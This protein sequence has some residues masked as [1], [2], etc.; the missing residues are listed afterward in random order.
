[1]KYCLHMATFFLSLLCLYKYKLRCLNHSFAFEPSTR[2]VWT[3]NKGRF[4]PYEVIECF[5]L[6]EIILAVR[7]NIGSLNHYW[8]FKILLVVLPTLGIWSII[9][10][11]TQIRYYNVLGGLK[12]YL[13]L[14]QFYNVWR[15]NVCVI[16]MICVW[17]IIS[18]LN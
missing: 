8:M 10:P 9:W 4:N 11:V 7:T 6:F 18:W 13:E 2:G 1:M 15:V 14:E 16:T 3:I 12:H 17:A 5:W